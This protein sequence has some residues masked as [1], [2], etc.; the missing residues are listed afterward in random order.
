MTDARTKRM[1]ETL[2]YIPSRNTSLC[3]GA[4]LRV[5]RAWRKVVSRAGWIE[6]AA[7]VCDWLFWDGP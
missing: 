5:G 1:K 4:Q 3:N 2:D 6:P 7:V